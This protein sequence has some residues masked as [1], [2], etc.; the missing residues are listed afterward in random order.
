[1]GFKMDLDRKLL[2]KQYNE[3]VKSHDGQAYRCGSFDEFVLDLERVG[4]DDR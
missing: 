3:Y 2:R 1:M 4:Q